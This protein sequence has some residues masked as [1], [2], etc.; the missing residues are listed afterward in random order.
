MQHY[1]IARY[2]SLRAWA[3]QLGMTDAMALIEADLAE[4]KAADEKL[5]KLS[6]NVDSEALQAAARGG[7]EQG[8]LCDRATKQ[9]DRWTTGLSCSSSVLQLVMWTRSGAPSAIRRRTGRRW[10][11]SSI[12]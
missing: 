3:S 4:E 12:R 8:T 2:G 6:R 5:N 7:S 10:P 11:R 9:A 1:E